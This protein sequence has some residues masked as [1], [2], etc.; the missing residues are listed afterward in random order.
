MLV[1]SGNQL[2]LLE[3][4]FVFCW[5]DFYINKSKPNC[6]FFFSSHFLFG[7]LVR[8]DIARFRSLQPATNL[9]GGAAEDVCGEQ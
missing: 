7:L 6:L 8:A 1:S 9:D 4:Q 2:E 3:I 5:H